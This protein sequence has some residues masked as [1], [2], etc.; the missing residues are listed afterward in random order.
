MVGTAEKIRFVLQVSED[1][2]N[3]DNEGY[4]EHTPSSG[5]NLWAL[6]FSYRLEGG[7][8]DWLEGVTVCCPLQL[9]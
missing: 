6:S 7:V 9:T 5:V 4:S 3:K 1:F 2:G 8:S